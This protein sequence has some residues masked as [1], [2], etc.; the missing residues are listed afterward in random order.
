MKDLRFMHIADLHLDSPFVG[1][2]QLPPL[3]FQTMKESTFKALTELVTIAINE[4]V[5]FVIIAGDIYD[6]QTQSIRAQ[7]RFIAEM[8]RLEQADIAVYA[9]TGNH[10]YRGNHEVALS[11]PSN[12]TLFPSETT[13]VIH[14]LGDGRSVALHG[15]SYDRR[16]IKDRRV[17][18]YVKD[19]TASY[20]IG[21][22]HGEE[23]TEGGNYAPF[24][25]DELLAKQFDYW[26]LGH[27]HKRAVLH[28]EPMIVYPG[29]IQ[30]RHRKETGQKGGY[31]VTLNELKTKLLFKEAAAIVWHEC[32]LEIE[33][34]MSLDHLLQKLTEQVDAVRQLQKGQAFLRIVIRS[35]RKLGKIVQQKINNNEVLERLQDLEQERDDF[36]WVYQIEQRLNTDV[37]ASWWQEDSAYQTHWLGAINQLKEAQAFNDSIQEM[38]MQRLARRYIEVPTDSEREQLIT[39]AT[40]LIGQL[41]AEEGETK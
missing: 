30:G 6:E 29:N 3:I 39:E 28:K 4:D 41:I 35:N 1:L 13:T 17:D 9:V 27:I 34:D 21:I 25:I 40:L 23:L 32:F 11:L 20:N 2:K 5:E 26:A 19:K 15:F 7:A 33:A 38:I 36:V 10:D 37:S 31:L 16:H 12:V 8:Q 14:E 18:T 22:Y 24:S